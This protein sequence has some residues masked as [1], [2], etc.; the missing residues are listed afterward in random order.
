[1]KKLGYQRGE[2]LIK[3]LRACLDSDKSTS[4][5]KTG[6]AQALC[7]CLNSLGNAQIEANWSQIIDAAQDQRNYIRESFLNM[8]V[9]MPLIINKEYERYIASTL[10][11]ALN[12]IDHTEENIRS[13]A[14]RSIK[15]IIQ[16][17]SENNSDII[18]AA[19][20]E[21]MFADNYLKRHSS[22][23]LLGDTI[24]VLFK[25]KTSKSD[26]YKNNPQIFAA[27]YVVKHDE[28]LD[29]KLATANVWANFVDNTMK[30]LKN[31]YPCL[32]DMYINLLVSGNEY[33]RDIAQVSLVDFAGKYGDVFGTEILAHLKEKM[34]LNDPKI[35]QGICALLDEIIINIK[36]DYMK[37]ARKNV[38]EDILGHL[39]R[40]GEEKVWKQ[41]LATF[42]DYYNKF[43]EIE[44]IE[45][46]V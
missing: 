9:F 3:G 5:E 43:G 21:G 12:S 4:V 20:F 17:F 7:E 23:I 26:I 45:K 30:C 35:N 29:V 39:I 18:L 38:V 36:A 34:M 27:L 22:V 14:V 28:T 31:T 16:K 37:R 1:M 25:S 42:R 2:K 24:D 46:I 11:A 6:C 44:F 10:K 15:I 8:L 33:H 32:V 19:L 13:L 40:N 41:A